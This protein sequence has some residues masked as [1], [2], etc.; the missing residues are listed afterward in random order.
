MTS[1]WRRGAVL[2]AF[3]SCWGFAFC[4]CRAQET[5]ESNRPVVTRVTPQYPSLARGMKLQGSV[6]VEAVVAPD[7]SAKTVAIKG[8]HPLLAQAAHD[9][10][11][12][13]K[14]VPA[15]AET[16]ELIEIK[17]NP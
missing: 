8:G 2:T 3:L 17:F 13:W 4:L 15:P 11:Q 14:W 12:K 6:K 5:S 10:V 9:A 7:G 16:R 1:G